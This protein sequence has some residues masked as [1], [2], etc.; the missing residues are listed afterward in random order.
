ML[1]SPDLV[2]NKLTMVWEEAGGETCQ[3]YRALGFGSGVGSEEKCED[4][5]VVGF[6]HL[7][8]R[9][10]FRWKSAGQRYT[11]CKLLS[12]LE[13]EETICVQQKETVTRSAQERKM[14]VCFQ[15]FLIC[16]FSSFPGTWD[17][18]SGTRTV[19]CSIYRPLLPWYGQQ[20]HQTRTC[21]GELQPR[22]H[23]APHRPVLHNHPWSH[24]RYHHF[25]WQPWE[26][27]WTDWH[28]QCSSKNGI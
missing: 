13:R 3:F 2:P 6:A 20:G 26:R 22:H 28:L 5:C 19:P 8:K 24:R 27:D 12:Q 15:I 1:S 16:L 10:M 14:T 18:S 25:Q 17:A 11:R 21:A 4:L 7:F 23:A 9:L